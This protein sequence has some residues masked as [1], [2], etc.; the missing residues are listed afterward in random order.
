MA[1]ITGIVV[2]LVLIGVFWLLRSMGS[3]GQKPSARERMKHNAAD[4]HQHPPR[5][6]GLD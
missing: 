4:Q 3:M 5:A 2:L 6:S 1:A